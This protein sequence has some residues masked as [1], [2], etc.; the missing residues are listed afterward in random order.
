[1]K[2]LVSALVLSRL[3]YC[4]SPFAGLS[5]DKITKLQRI[6]NNAARLIPKQPNGHH[7]SPLLKDL[8]GRADN[9]G[10]FSCNFKNNRARNFTFCMHTLK[11]IV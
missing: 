1:M 10:P 9:K 6:Q 2:K 11:P 8:R 7:V 3:D 5:N 4:N